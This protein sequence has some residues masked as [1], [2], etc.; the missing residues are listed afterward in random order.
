[1]VT[2]YRAVSAPGDDSA[3]HRRNAQ[4]ALSLDAQSQAREGGEFPAPR[5]LSGL[6]TAGVGD[7]REDALASI[8]LTAAVPPA[9]A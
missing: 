9:A 4:E 7:L 1:L 5:G 3:E 6:K 8:A 2:I